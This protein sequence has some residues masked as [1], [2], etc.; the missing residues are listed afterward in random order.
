[1]QKEWGQEVGIENSEDSELVMH[2]C[3]E[4][5]VETDAELRQVLAGRSVL[6]FVEAHWV[7]DHPKV[8]DA[9]ASLQAFIEAPQDTSSR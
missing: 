2:H 3:H 8:G 9:I 6:E 4:L 7:R 5:L 1:M